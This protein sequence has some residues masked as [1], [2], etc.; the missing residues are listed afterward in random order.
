MSVTDADADDDLTQVL[1]A[2][3][4]SV[5]AWR[6]GPLVQREGGGGGQRVSAATV[7]PGAATD[8]VVAKVATLAQPLVRIGPAEADVGQMLEDRLG[9]VR[10]DPT[11]LMEAPA[12]VVAAPPGPA[13]VFTGWPLLEMHRRVWAKAGIG[14]GRL[15]VMERAPFPK[16]A[17]LGRED[18]AP[19]AAGFV[20]CHDGVAMMHALE[21]LPR[22]RRRGVGARMTRAAAR[23][24][25]AQGASRFALAVTEANTGARALY[26]GLGLREVG[27]YHY[28]VGRNA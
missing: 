15:A 25:V 27:R 20:A 8:D 16:T 17:L 10:K 14:P 21:V 11:I 6:D 26:T 2:T 3:W 13:K 23:W 4:P 9:L 28:L 18:D 7:V 5:R 19:L 22:I 12:A 24:A 1:E